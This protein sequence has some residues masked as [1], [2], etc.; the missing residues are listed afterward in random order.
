[1]KPREKHRC[2]SIET[3]QQGSI[4]VFQA[5]CSC[6]EKF[7]DLTHAY[8]VLKMQRHMTGGKHFIYFR[9]ASNN[10]RLTCRCARTLPSYDEWNHMNRH[11]LILEDNSFILQKT[12]RS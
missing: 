6:G 10:G 7:S 1:M 12:Y 3:V 4:M 2:M 11:A 5:L 8:T 9:S